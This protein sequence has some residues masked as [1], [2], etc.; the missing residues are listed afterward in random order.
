MKNVETMEYRVHDNN[1]AEI[2]VLTDVF[3][4]GFIEGME[5][6]SFTV[7][8]IHALTLVGIESKEALDFLLQLRLI[9]CEQE[10]QKEESRQEEIEAIKALL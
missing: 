10:L 3:G 6:I 9:E 5:D 2:D 1:V 7:G 8:Q 4:E